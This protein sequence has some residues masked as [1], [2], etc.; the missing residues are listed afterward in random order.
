MIH[1]VRKG[2]PILRHPLG[3]SAQRPRWL[4]CEQDSATL[5]GSMSRWPVWAPAP[6]R[7]SDTTGCSRLARGPRLP[8]RPCLQVPLDCGQGGRAGSWCLGPRNVCTRPGMVGFP[9]RRRPPGRSEER[10]GRS[11][12]RNG[13]QGESACRWP[14]VF[15]T[16]AIRLRPMTLFNL[17]FNRLTPKGV[18]RSI[19]QADEGLTPADEA[20]SVVLRQPPASK[21]ANLFRIDVRDHGLGLVT[22]QLGGR[23]TE[24]PPAGW[25]GP[26]TPSLREGPGSASVPSGSPDPVAGTSAPARPCGRGKLAQFSLLQRFAVWWVAPPWPILSV[27]AVLLAPCRLAEK[28]SQF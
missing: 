11:E 23:V 27:A 6:E 9:V 3:A 12:E 5:A 10:N 20:G 19:T 18:K 14:Q 22:Q 25:L 4:R 2:P 8:A 15:H 7:A 13:R 28:Q 24:H 26:R 21:L 16:Q 1:I 17:V